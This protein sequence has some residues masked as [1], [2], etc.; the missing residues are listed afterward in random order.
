LLLLPDGL[1]DDY[2]AREADRLADRLV[3]ELLRLLT[4]S[5]GVPEQW[6]AALSP[7]SALQQ[8]CRACVHA[9]LAK[10]WPAKHTDL[11]SLAGFGR[12]GFYGAK[13]IAL[14]MLR[15][16]FLLA[17]WGD[18]DAGPLPTDDLVRSVARLHAAFQPLAAPEP[19][20]FVAAQAADSDLRRLAL[21]AAAAEIA[22]R[23]LVALVRSAAP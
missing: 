2:R 5:P 4:G 1:F 9:M 12:S 16:R 8:D 3:M 22:R 19:A 15:C 17:E 13:A 20:T 6:A 14:S 23:Y 11:V 10:R 7:G 21:P 18:P